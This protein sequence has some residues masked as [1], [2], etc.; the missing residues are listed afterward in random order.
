MSKEKLK[1]LQTDGSGGGGTM[2][3]S[4]DNNT[5]P[6]FPAQNKKASRLT[7]TNDIQDK[8]IE[9]KLLGVPFH[10]DG[11]NKKAYKGWYNGERIES[12]R[13]RRVIEWIARYVGGWIG[14]EELERKRL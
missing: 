2:A 13:E 6:S 11:K 1:M 12:E 10:S 4:D 9:K 7:E 8:K 14:D 5:S 3:S